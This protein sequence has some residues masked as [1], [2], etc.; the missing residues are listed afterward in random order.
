PA[1]RHQVGENRGSCL[2]ELVA[3]TIADDETQDDRGPR[4][5]LRSNRRETLARGCETADNDQDQQKQ[6]DEVRRL[7]VVEL[8]CGRGNDQRGQQK[9][10]EAGEDKK[11]QAEAPSC[12][13]VLPGRSAAGILVAAQGTTLQAIVSPPRKR[14]S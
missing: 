1:R 2:R 4:R 12:R 7:M 8:R 10:N 11:A 14:R 13:R 9:K 6:I 3:K 5:E